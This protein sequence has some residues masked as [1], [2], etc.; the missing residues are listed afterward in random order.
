MRRFE[1]LVEMEIKAL[2]E[3]IEDDFKRLSEITNYERISLLIE[4]LHQLNK[5]KRIFK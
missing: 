3:S 2:V 5:A 1:N 4:H